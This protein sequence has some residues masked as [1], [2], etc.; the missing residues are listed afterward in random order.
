MM[1]VVI[2]Q[3]FWKDQGMTMSKINT[4]N[5]KTFVFE[6]VFPKIIKPQVYHT[7]EVT[8]NESGIPYV[9]RS[10]FNNG[11]KYFV[12][13][14]HGEINPARVISFGAE[15]ATF[16]YQE[17]EWVSGRDI[18]YTDTTEIDKYACLFITACLQPI[19]AK[20]SYNFGLFPDLLR[21]EK[22]KLPVDK[23][24]KPDFLYMTAYM[25]K[26]ESNV[27]SSI[28]AIEALKTTEFSKPINTNHWKEFQLTEVL[29]LQRQVEISPIQAYFDNTNS[30]DQYPFYGQSKINNGI[31]SYISLDKKYLNNIEGR[32]AILIHSNTHECVYADRPF[33]L[34]DGHGATSIF[35]NDKLDKYSTLYIMSVLS[36]TM[37][38]SFD[39]DKKATKEALKKLK[40]RLPVDSNGDPDYDHMSGFMKA[41]ECNSTLKLTTLSHV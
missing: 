5:W 9:V 27:S 32:Y 29:N 18:Y 11:I 34:K 41:L 2:Y 6:Q 33:Y 19:A 17:Q 36:K 21:K 31:I 26:I 30:T 14:P 22:I 10:K 38:G 13:K 8:I 39:Y 25:K 16:F 37:S 15:N 24:G 40:I 20:Y 28:I 23:D 4:E 35:S 12:T 7:R 1:R 3:L